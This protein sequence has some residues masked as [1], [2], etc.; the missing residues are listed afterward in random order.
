MMV[1]EKLR[2]DNQICFRVYS[3]ERAILATYRPHLKKLGITYPQYLVLMALWEHRFLTI[4]RLCELL[5]LDT[6]TVSPLVK[7]MEK[8]NLLTRNRLPEDE[9]TVIVELSDAGVRLKDRAANIPDEIGKCI[10][11]RKNGSV[12]VE[13][14]QRLRNALDEALATLQGS[15][16]S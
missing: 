10:L 6:G 13:A 15:S 3:L 1:D 14:F 5:G 12:D 8:Q 7:R 16:C 2:L 9:R 11:G 4:G